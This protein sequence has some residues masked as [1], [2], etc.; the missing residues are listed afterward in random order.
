MQLK[1]KTAAL[2]LACTFGGGV[3][4]AC[5]SNDDD[6]PRAYASNGSAAGSVHL[7]EGTTV[8]SAELADVADVRADRVVFPASAFDALSVRKP[9]D[10]LLSDRQRAG[11]TGKNPE[12]FLRRVTSVGRSPDGT[13]VMTTPATL[14]EAV[15]SLVLHT[16]LDVPDLTIEGPVSTTA[17]RPLAN[18]GTTIKLL[19][20][21]GKQLFEVKDTAKGS[22]GMDVPYVI[23]AGVETGTLGFSPSYEV[24][25]DV[26]F[27]QLESF[28]VA[29]TG[30]LEAKLVLAAGVKLDPSVSAARAAT[31]AGKPLTKS[32]S[33]SLADYD[34]SLGSVGL[35]GVSLPASVHF[36][37][38]L[39]C[40]FSFTAPV[41]AKVGGT[42][43]GSITAALSYKDGTLTPS[44]DKAFAFEP[45]APDFTKQGMARAYCTVSPT[46]QLKFFGAATAELSANA[47]AGIGAS[48]TCGGADAA[49][50][51]QALVIGDA[52]VGVSAKVL[53]QVDLFGLYKWK[54]ECTLFSVDAKKRYDTTYPYPGS[55]AATCTVAGPF[56]LPPPV[57]A[58]PEACFGETDR[59][60]GS[61][62]TNAADGGSDGGA[63]ADGEAG[64]LIPGACTHDVCTAGEPLGQACDECTMKVCAAD[65]YCCD[66]FWGLSC[67]DSVEKHCGKKCG[68]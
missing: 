43:S 44:F 6:A 15:D 35:G 8:L 4:G 17:L 58:N 63:D 68:Q 45:M 57:P 49:G 48:Q 5:S 47:Y 3:I 62:P 24:D 25:A 13:V 46:F 41:E 65:A 2:F 37:A 39:N 20:Y 67:F 50:V 40:D 66:T 9:G 53:A 32:F 19:D 21:S 31:L 64:S 1:K 12:G 61:E 34:V 52:E 28:K 60:T 30:K 36:S 23:Y 38:S 54:K 11:T 18:G 56:P 16:K 22:D 10:V 7:H 26:A 33:K 29:A 59:G 55:P 27:M 51:S 42:A 14:Q